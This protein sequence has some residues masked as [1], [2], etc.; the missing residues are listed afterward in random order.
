[1]AILI[2]AA[3]L[4]IQRS[5]IEATNARVAEKTFD[6]LLKRMS[7]ERADHRVYITGAIEIILPLC[8]T[9]LDGV[10]EANTQMA[11][12]GLRILAVAVAPSG[13]E[14]NAT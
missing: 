5:E 11:E 12:R 8:S 4:G 1:M 9:S 7:I 13:A 6:K 14:S 10:D 3:E 2:A